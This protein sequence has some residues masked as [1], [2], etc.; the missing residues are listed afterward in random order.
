MA[1]L[2]F[3]LSNVPVDEILQVRQQLQENDIEF[4]E[5]DSG[6]FGVGV[7][8]IWLPDDQQLAHAKT[9]LEQYQS[10]RLASAQQ[11]HT[12]RNLWQ[13]FIQAPVRFVFSFAVVAAILYFSIAPFMLD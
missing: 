13:S 9:I 4:Y 5:T 11:D 1:E 10:E 7:A 8:A 12:E 6:A 2:L 3:K